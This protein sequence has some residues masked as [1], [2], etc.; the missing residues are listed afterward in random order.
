MRHLTPVVVG[1]AL[2]LALAPRVAAEQRPRDPVIT[3]TVYNATSEALFINGSLLKDGR[4]TPTVSFGGTPV[5]VLSA[6]PS[7]V[8]VLVPNATPAGSY[9]VTLLRTGKKPVRVM[10]IATIGAA[11]AQGLPGAPGPPGAAGP[12]GPAGSQGTTGPPGNIGPAGPQGIQGIAGPQ[13]PAGPPG[14]AGP[15]GPQG[16]P[17]VSVQGT[18]G[19]S[20]LEV[21]QADQ[22]FNS[23]GPSGVV[24]VNAMCPA[25]KRVLA[26]GAQALSWSAAPGVLPLM[27]QSFPFFNSWIV[28]FANGHPSGTITNLSV[29]TFAI[30]AAAQ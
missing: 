11:G 28:L 3:S 23:L 6:T 29:R 17:G 12:E 9:L 7:Q 1:A 13:G 18:A 5:T 25:P 4:H 14:P 10:T 20:G 27:H 2:V 19:L 24:Q 26:G 16:I 15:Q 22:F 30:C 8:V 21:V